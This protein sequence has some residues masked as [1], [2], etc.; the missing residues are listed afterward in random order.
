MAVVTISRDLGSG[1]S[2]VGRELADTVG[3]RYLNHEGILTRVKAVGAKWEK[4]AQ[5]F[6]EHSP[7]LWEKYD[8][9]YRGYIALMQSIIME[10]AVLDRVVVIG[11]GANYLLRGTP[12][13][14][15][16]RIVA[17]VAGRASRLSQRESIDRDSARLLIER[18]DRE[19]SGFLYMV[20][21]RNGKSTEDYDLSFDSGSTSLPE[22]LTSIQTHMPGKDSL[23][24][25]PS[26]RT[27]QMKTLAARIKARLLTGLPFFLATLEVTWDGDCITVRSVVRLRERERVENE[28]KSLA[29]DTPIKFELRYRQ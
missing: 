18:T 11:R 9:S 1:G 14:L 6:D 20:Y 5:D 2:E 27:L 17:P 19:R 13:V 8:W 16:V 28:A 7:R 12:F 4:W 26:R 21:G 3:Y 22:I 29:G 15:S 10:E 24:D 25:E 23:R